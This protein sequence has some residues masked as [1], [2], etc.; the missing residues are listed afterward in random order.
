M[1]IGQFSRVIIYAKKKR[2]LLSLLSLSHLRRFAVA[3]IYSEG[4][5]LFWTM[6]KRQILPSYLPVEGIEPSNI[7]LSFPLQIS[8]TARFSA[9]KWNE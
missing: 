2:Q 5:D 8:K 1:A 4:Q 9:L 6:S 7:Y 3:R